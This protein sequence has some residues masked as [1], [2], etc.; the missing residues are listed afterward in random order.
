MAD[1]W[2]K[3]KSIFLTS[4]CHKIYRVEAVGLESSSYTLKITILWICEIWGNFSKNWYFVNDCLVK[5]QI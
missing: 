2:Q 5:V 4:P 1:N 3:W